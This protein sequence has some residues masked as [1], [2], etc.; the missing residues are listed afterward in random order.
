MPN[1]KNLQQVELLKTKIAKAKS[2]A[3]VDYSGTSANDQVKLRSEVTAAGG[4]V[5]VAKNTLIDI[6][7]GKGK[8]TD[9]LE[10]MNAIVFSYNDAVAAIKSLFNFQKDASKLEIKQGFMDDKVLSADEVKSL[11]KLPGKNELISM[12]ISRLQ[13]PATG[14]VNVLKAG[15][16][17]LV[18]ALNAIVDKK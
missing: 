3:I 17:N 2:I 11:S 4:E 10:G 16:R 18:Y 15:P 1:V 6:A 8:L 7:V 12:L 13:S 9:S 14:L 5:L